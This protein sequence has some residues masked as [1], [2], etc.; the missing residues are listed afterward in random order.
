[1]RRTSYAV[2]CRKQF[3]RFNQSMCIVHCAIRNTH[4]SNVS[5][6]SKC[7]C[8]DCGVLP[9]WFIFRFIDKIWKFQNGHIGL[10]HYLLKHKSLHLKS[11]DRQLLCEMFLISEAV[12]STQWTWTVKALE[13]HNSTQHPDQYWIVNT[14]LFNWNSCFWWI[15]KTYA[16]WNCILHCTRFHC[17]K[18]TI[19]RNGSS[20]NG[21]KNYL[22]FVV[23][24]CETTKSMQ[25]LWLTSHTRAENLVQVF[26]F[27]WIYRKIVLF[28]HEVRVKLRREA[29]LFTILF[30]LQLNSIFT[31]TIKFGHKSIPNTR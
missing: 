6:N 23:N 16:D 8:L 26:G 14:D 4:D 22:V 25:L 30:H 3:C 13:V 10:T 20:C 12:Q 24:G 18:F 31:W 11:F 5:Q 7:V 29:F 9:F 15:F 28:P 17:L 1:M 21:L 19:T 2:Q 27:C